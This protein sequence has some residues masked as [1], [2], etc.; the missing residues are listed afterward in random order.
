MKRQPP[1]TVVLDMGLRGRG[2]TTR[3]SKSVRSWILAS[4]QYHEC[5]MC[6][7]KKGEN[8]SSDNICLGRIIPREEYLKIRNKP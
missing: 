1:E 4:V 7:A 6:R 3:M 5:P 8:C 2:L